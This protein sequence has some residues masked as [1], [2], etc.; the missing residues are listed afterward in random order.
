MGTVRRLICRV[1]GGLI[2]LRSDAEILESYEVSRLRQPA[3]R[4]SARHDAQSRRR[5]A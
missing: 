3:V 1:T 2:D 5:A 4:G